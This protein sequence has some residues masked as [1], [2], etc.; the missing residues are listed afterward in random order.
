MKFAKLTSLFAFVTLAIFTLAFASAAVDVTAISSSS[1]T[2]SVGSQLTFVVN[3]TATPAHTGTFT[4]AQLVLPNLFG[5]T[6]SW[7]GDTGTFTL[8]P[9]SSVTK[10][11]TLSIPVGQ[12]PSQYSGIINFSGTYSL[13]SP[14][15]INGLPIAVTVNNPGAI[16]VS[17]TG[18]E[19]AGSSQ[20]YSLNSNVTLAVSS[21]TVSGTAVMSTAS[22]FSGITFT[23]SSFTLSSTPVSVKAILKSLSGLKFGDNTVEVR[24]TSGQ[25]FG[26]TPFQVRKT[27]CSSGQSAI[28]NLTIEGVSWDNN[29]EG[30]EDSWELLDEIEVEMDIRNNNNDDDVDVVAVLGLFDK[31]GN[32]VANDLTFIGDSADDEEE[33]KI[34]IDDDDEE[35]VRWEFKVPADFDSGDYKLAVKVYDDDRNEANDCVD[36]NNDLD[37]NYFQSIKVEETDDEGRFIIVDDIEL[38][39]QIACGETVSG[40]FTVF[41]VGDEDQDRVRV[42]IKNAELGIN[43]VREITSDLNQGD[44]DNLD[45]T[46]NIP[47]TARSGS[48]TLEFFTEYD[49][50]NGVYRQDGDEPAEY[51]IELIGCTQNTG[52]NGNG[53]GLTNIKI[54]ADLD[55]EA[56]AGEELVI[57]ATISNTGNTDASYT[58]SARGYSSWAEL[59]DISPSTISVDAGESETVRIVMLVDDAA[60]GTQSFDL[61]VASDGRTQVQEI[62]VKLAEGTSASNVFSGS[63]LIWIIAAIN[64]ILIILIIVVAVRM[65]R[66]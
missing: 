2:G 64:I 55:S 35:T 59:D 20:P 32:N 17:I 57:L 49:Y 51:G 27:F 47:A 8:N 23:P 13:T 9:S 45:F 6:T 52:N 65:S 11:V 16:A 58:I 39:S 46:I 66:R 44:D 5:P 34:N 62:E 31:N 15:N 28:S 18:T 24:A 19:P 43:E 42:T 61:Q 40:Q 29:G 4:N 22:P 41:N 54:D 10:T 14:P 36:T 38:D 60:T 48:Y 25:Q 30:D 50:K 56:K 12:T 63:S 7:S 53:Q 21:S 26:S 37:N 33:V 1:Q 3:V